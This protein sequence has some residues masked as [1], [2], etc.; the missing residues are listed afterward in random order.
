MSIDTT[1]RAHRPKSGRFAPLA[2]LFA[3]ASWMNFAGAMITVGP[4]GDSACQFHDVT[5]AV[6]AADQS[7]GVD[8]VAIS[9]GTYTGVST[10]IIVSGDDLIVEGGFANCSAGIS[11]GTSTLDADGAVIHGSLF[12]HYGSGRLTLLH[13]VLTHGDAIAGGGVDSEGTG[14]LTLSDVMLL[15]NTADY[16]GGVFAVGG[17]IPHKEVT[18]IGAQFNSNIA[19]G[20]G[21]GL[22]AIYSDVTIDR[23]RPSYFLGNFANG[24]I[25][26][27]GD[28]GGIYAIDSNVIAK[29]HGVAGFPFIG[30][31]I[32]NRNGGGVY[33]DARSGGAYE[34]FLW[35]DSANQPLEISYN[36]AQTGG[37]V[38]MYAY[39]LTQ[40]IVSYANFRNTIWR[41]NTAGSDGAALHAESIGGTF[42]V[43]TTARFE[44]SRVGDEAPPCPANL[45]CNAFE[46]NLSHSG[47]IISGVGGGTEGSTSIEFFR[48]RMIDNSTVSG[49]GGLIFGGQGRVWVDGSLFARNSLSGDLI[50]VVDSELRFQNS[51][52]ARN[53]LGANQL[54][55]AALVPSTVYILHSLL[56]QPNDPVDAFLVG[57]SIPVTVRDVGAESVSGLPTGPGNNVQFLTDPFVDA[58][59]GDFHIRTTS[60]AVDRWA[61]VAGDPYDIEPTLDLDGALRPH[62]FNS[63]T[64]PYDFGAYEAGSIIDAIFVDGFES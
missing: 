45:G 42:D 32:A 37:G 40:Q 12:G 36:A 24:T 5:S 41:E 13:L 15:N 59:Q 44:Q 64:T 20:S 25:T 30:N 7:P 60:S 39:S 58:S 57:T 33:F 29:T 11:T 1:I 27:T 46:R 34:L 49:G 35:N 50:G 19:R 3:F 2:I 22:Y 62:V 16:G 51:T 55:T 18:L 54:F 61:Y 48:G 17:P 23:S 56:S 26:N 14:A 4:D 47:Y 10:A 53:T 38:F 63:T 43:S 9:A 31:N 21:G 6:I 52:V 8:L 28:G